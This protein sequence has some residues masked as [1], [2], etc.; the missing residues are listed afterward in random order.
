MPGL[1]ELF[2]RGSIAEQIF[3]WGVLNNV[4]SAAGSPFFLEL[5]YRI[6]QQF[7]LTEHTPADLAL[8][9]VRNVLSRNAA[10]AEA[11]RAGINGERFDQLTAITG[12]AP[13]PGDLAVG[14]RRKLISE[15]GTGPESTSYE[16]GIREGRLKDKWIPLMREL[17]TEWPT[18]DDILEA[19]LQGQITEQEAQPLYAQMG[20]EQRFFDLLFHTRGAGPTPVQAG[21]LANREIIP[22]DGR[23]PAAT[24]FEQA[25]LESRFR[26]KWH[27]AYRALAEYRPPPRTI[28][29]MLRAGSITK[30][31]AATLL[32]QYGL[33]AELAA[34][35]IADAT[36]SKASTGKELTEAQIVGLFES[37]A[38]TKAEATS[39][40]VK[41]GLS[42]HDAGLILA[43]AGAR[44][45]IGQVNA[46]VTRI[47]ASFL[48]R[49]IDSAQALHSLAAIGISTAAGE[50]MVRVWSAELAA[51]PRVLSDAAIA[52]ALYYKVIGQDEAMRRLEAD[53]WRPIDAWIL[54]SNRMH[55]PLPNRPAG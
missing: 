26:N 7:P 45:E 46:A 21:V 47:R 51:S 16:Q 6:N 10:A 8:M 55:G 35:Y 31:Q 2:G 48:A 19:L 38:A 34:A 32:R 22:W 3:V 12:D 9:V 11:K 42:E 25:F 4:I 53:G 14:L 13:A 1:G 23:G 37:G 17:A 41:Y 43:A 5:T 54:L 20:G 50:P 49:H 36:H 29:A 28:T 24:T 30:E 15:Q 33:T 40:L 27:D 39:M 52:A 18:P 44:R